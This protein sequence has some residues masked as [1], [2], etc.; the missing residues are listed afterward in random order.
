[1]QPLA[2]KQRQLCSSVGKQDVFLQGSVPARIGLHAIWGQM[3]CCSHASLLHALELKALRLHMA[4]C[5]HEPLRVFWPMTA[6]AVGKQPLA[7]RC[8]RSTCSRWPRA[9]LG[10]K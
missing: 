9:L 4:F 5:E 6:A 8:H 2:T 7:A 1:M 10:L 3:V